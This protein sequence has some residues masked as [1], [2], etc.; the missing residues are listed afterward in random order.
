MGTDIY[1]LSGINHHDAAVEKVSFMVV[2]FIV[3][4]VCVTLPRAE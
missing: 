3:V 1:L 2:L 4:S